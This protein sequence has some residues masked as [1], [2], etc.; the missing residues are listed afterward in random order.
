MIVVRRQDVDLQVDRSPYVTSHR[1]AVKATMSAGPTLPDAA[2]I[3]KVAPCSQSPLRWGCDSASSGS[4]RHLAG[5]CC[6]WKNRHMCTSEVLQ[7]IL[8]ASG[9]AITLA[10]IVNTVRVSKR[11]LSDAERRASDMAAL[12]AEG[13]EHGSALNARAKE[14]AA[15]TGESFG[16][17]IQRLHDEERDSGARAARYAEKGLVAP[18][19]SNMASLAILETTRV[20][21]GLLRANR[22]NAWLL[23]SGLVLSGAGSIWAL[24]T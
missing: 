18:V 15:R 24:Y 11:D 3:Q 16:V 22:I 2:A 12:S 1:T 9:T 13:A 10:A 14:E 23:A 19:Y 8:I 21:R 5:R 20:A 6:T 4:C 7:T 17:V